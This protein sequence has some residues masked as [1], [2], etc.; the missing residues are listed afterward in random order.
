MER[1]LSPG[2]KYKHYSPNADLFLLKTTCFDDDKILNLIAVL[3]NFCQT[4]KITGSI[5]LTTPIYKKTNDGNDPPLIVDSF[6][7]AS[8]EVIAKELFSRLRK[9]DSLNVK[10]ILM[11]SV[12]EENEGSAIMNRLLKASNSILTTNEEV[13][14]SLERL[15]I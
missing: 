7:S 11:F 6:S 10:F 5:L 4:N 9:L 1:P 8:Y 2:M 15:L 3:E 13:I 12:A 14:H